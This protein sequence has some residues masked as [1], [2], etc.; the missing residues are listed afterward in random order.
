MRQTLRAS[1]AIHPLVGSA[2][3][4]HAARLTYLQLNAKVFHRSSP[5]TTLPRRP[6]F[7]Q[8][9]DG[10][11]WVAIG[12]DKAHSLLIADPRLAQQ[13]ICRHQARFSLGIPLIRRSNL[14][15]IRKS[16]SLVAPSWRLRLSL[17]SRKFCGYS[18]THIP[19]Q[20]FF[21]HR[22]TC[23]QVEYLQYFRRI[24]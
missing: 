18:S 7:F 2:E 17:P 20:G 5:D 8:R 23:S 3:P 1:P 24:L 6:H 9:S 16:S 22:K 11:A 4:Q 12:A 10:L 15:R 19:C 13:P 21:F 14:S